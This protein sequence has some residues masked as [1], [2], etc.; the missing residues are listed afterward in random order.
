MRRH[1]WFKN[2]PPS[3]AGLNGANLPRKMKIPA[4]ISAAIT[5]R[6]GR[7]GPAQTLIDSPPSTMPNAADE[8]MIPNI[9]AEVK[10][11]TSGVTRTVTNPRK[12][13]AAVNSVAPYAGQY[14]P[15]HIAMTPTAAYTE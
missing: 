3:P 2:A 9:W 1:G 7:A 11:K 8:R 13:F 15:A 4:T 10:L 6:A 12:K 14:N 5:H